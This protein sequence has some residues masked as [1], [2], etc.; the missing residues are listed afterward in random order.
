MPTVVPLASSSIATR[1]ATDSSP[2]VGTAS[3]VAL[4]NAR[5]M[6]RTQATRQ[7]RRRRYPE[8]YADEPKPANVSVSGNAQ[9]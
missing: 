1:L 3:S 9:R 4:R 2:S 5:L 8:L 6:T 7:A